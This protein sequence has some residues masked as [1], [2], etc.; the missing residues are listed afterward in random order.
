LE[1]F[2]GDNSSN[3]SVTSSDTV[4]TADTKFTDETDGKL[5]FTL[6]AGDDFYNI[7]YEPS[8]GIAET[9]DFGL[10]NTFNDLGFPIL[11]QVLSSGETV[12]VFA[13]GQ[14]NVNGD[15]SAALIGANDDFH[16]GSGNRLA[17]VAVPTPSAALAGLA[18]FGV[19]GLARR[20]RH[21]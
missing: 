16:V 11:P 2:F 21:A 5:T 4:A 13:A 9:F 3:D 1:I 17:F 18:L 10:T 15:G 19:I 6:V 12:D 20:K 7:N 8:T 14:F